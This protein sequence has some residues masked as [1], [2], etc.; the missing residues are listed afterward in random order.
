WKAKNNT[1]ITARKKS[2]VRVRINGHI[3]TG[4]RAGASIFGI[5]AAGCAFIVGTGGGATLGAGGIFGISGGEAAGILGR[6][7]AANFPLPAARA[8]SASASSASAGF[9]R[10]MICV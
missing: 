7:E 5:F 3:D 4:G 9:G 6:E 1:R 2:T 8:C 10:E